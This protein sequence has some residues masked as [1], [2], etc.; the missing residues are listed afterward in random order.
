MVSIYYS[1]K[2]FLTHLLTSYGIDINVAID[3]IV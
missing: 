3:N 1:K 2:S